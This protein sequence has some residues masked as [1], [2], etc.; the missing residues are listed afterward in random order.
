LALA[1]FRKQGEKMASRVLVVDDAVLVRNRIKEIV[2]AHGL[3]VVGEAANGVEAVEK[4]R[5]LKPD[6]TIMD[7]IMPFVNGIQATRDIVAEDPKASIVISCALGQ[8]PLVAEAIEA[9]AIDFITKPFVDDKVV[10]VVRK[11]LTR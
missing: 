6:L 5:T 3:E 1:E 2:T 8:E 7:I 9:G 4:Y 10:H 11:A